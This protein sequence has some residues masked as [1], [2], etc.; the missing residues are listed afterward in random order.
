MKVKGS[1]QALQSSLDFCIKITSTGSIRSVEGLRKHFF[2]IFLS[3]ERE[4]MSE[5]LEEKRNQEQTL[6]L[7]DE[8]IILEER[9]EEQVQEDINSPFN[10]SF[11]LKQVQLRASEDTK[12]P[13][14][15]DS[16]Y[17]SHGVYLEDIVI[18]ESE[19]EAKQEDKQE[20]FSIPQGY[21]E[22]GVMLD[23]VE[24][25]VCNTP[26]NET[27]Q[28]INNTS[29]V[30]HGIYLED[31]Q[32]I[33][34]PSVFPIEDE[35]EDEAIVDLHEESRSEEKTQL[36]DEVVDLEEQYIVPE[37]P[38][39]KL[40]VTKDEE[41]TDAPKEI[42]DFLRQHPNA[43]IDFVAKFYSKKEIAKQVKLG[44]IYKKNGKLMI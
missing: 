22:H 35:N 40:E 29:Y 14:I 28:V 38:E 7:E 27:V 32:S 10:S 4:Q 39:V 20:K 31:M 18:P 36:K 24:V 26:T 1:T 43:S 3:E 9:N 23:D 37:E 19:P 34:V 30:E 17:T 16:N 2:G 41:P 15:D 11:F 12:T 5:M 13:A 21:I 44:R 42:R 33:I 25:E 6:E 8:P